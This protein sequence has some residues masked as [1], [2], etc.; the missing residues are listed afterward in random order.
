MSDFSIV[1]EK[2]KSKYFDLLALNKAQ[3]EELT[4][5]NSELQEKNI[6]IKA[7]E[8]EV[9]NLQAQL[10]KIQEENITIIDSF[11]QKEHAL[12]EEIKLLS[13]SNQVDFKGIV[14]EIDECINLV[15][16]NL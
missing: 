6:R 13:K 1:I 16:N 12:N 8:E 14:R 9:F 5:I 7:L 4:L 2:I 15:K 10:K 3:K 11:K